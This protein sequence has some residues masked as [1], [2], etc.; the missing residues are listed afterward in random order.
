MP[1]PKLED[2]LLPDGR[3]Y[4]DNAATTK[5]SERAL[6]VYNE[7]A[8]RWF[9]NPMS[10][11]DF[12]PEIEKLLTSSR[13]HVAN[14]LGGDPYR[15]RVI[16]T[17]GATESLNILLTGYFLQN[18]GNRRKIVTSPIEHKAVLET[19]SYLETIGAELEFVNVTSEGVIDY[20][21]LEEIVD[22]NTLF[23]CL[24]H[25]NNETGEI[26]DL[27]KIYSI[28]SE[29]GSKFFTDT[30]QSVTKLEVDAK[31]FDAC[32]GSAHKFNG[33]KGVGFLYYSM[34]QN[35]KSLFNGGSQ[36]FDLRPGTHDLPAIVSMISAMTMKNDVNID[37]IE[38]LIG[39]ISNVRAKCLN[40]ANP[41]IQLWRIPYASLNELG[42]KIIYGKGSACSS[43]LVEHSEVYKKL[44]PMNYKEIIRLSI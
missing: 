33:P 8:E 4:F 15:D 31:F 32:V 17:S 23:T 40:R 12:D 38:N 21:H 35:I 26:S 43:G 3:Y 16:F 28:T 18:C 39:E 7:T 41:W 34:G 13:E 2:Y 10:Y 36:E 20:K 9:M 27:E 5:M 22:E 24:M 6:Q 14:F 37:C 29:V 25:V 1:K 11:K 42:E 19:C 44:F 30:T